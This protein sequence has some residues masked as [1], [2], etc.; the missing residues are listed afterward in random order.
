MNTPSQIDAH[1][2]VERSGGAFYVYLSELHRVGI[3]ATEIRKRL[4]DA[5]DPDTL[6][7]DQPKSETDTSTSDAVNSSMEEAEKDI[8]FPLQESAI[9]YEFNT[10]IS[11]TVQRGSFVFVNSLNDPH[12]CSEIAALHFDDLV[13]G[14]RPKHNFSSQYK[15]LGNRIH[16][17]VDIIICIGDFQVDNQLQDVFDFP[18]ILLKQKGVS[19]PPLCIRDSQR[20][21]MQTAQ[22]S[23][24]ILIKLEVDGSNPTVFI[25]NVEVT[26][27]PLRV[28]LEDT[29]L[30]E[31]VNTLSTFSISQLESSG[32]SKNNALN[33]VPD[34][35]R[36]RSD[37]LLKPINVHQISISPL[38]LLL[39]V[40]A[41]VKLYIA[42]DHSPLNFGVIK[43]NHLL[44]TG[45]ELGR[46]LAIHYLTDIFIKA[47]K[48][49]HNTT[50]NLPKF[51]NSTLENC[52][53]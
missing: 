34:A 14:L 33:I 25:E 13:V 52:V 27:K 51:L 18:V 53:F 5:H 24:L 45:Y 2:K 23:S 21:I 6:S 28:Y 19:I 36:M 22:S 1:V 12:K 41:S 15:C 30:T 26:M 29:F 48:S 32:I 11:C 44:T 17:I 40:H 8:H 42:L 49:N 31:L 47:G 7:D 46:D 39:T 20:N 38:S 9:P 35:V 50:S 37:D 10:Y 3:S 16:K 43:R 4:S